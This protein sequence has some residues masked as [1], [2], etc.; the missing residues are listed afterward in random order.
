M[1]SNRISASTKFQNLFFRLRDW[2]LTHSNRC[3][4]F[5]LKSIEFES[6]P[7]VGMLIINSVIWVEIGNINSFWIECDTYQLSWIKPLKYFLKSNILFTYLNNNEA[8]EMNIIWIC[9]L[10]YTYS[11]QMKSW[12]ISIHKPVIDWLNS[13]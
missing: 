2:C 8:I 11:I 1:Y 3:L 4:L 9:N 6:K 13:R 7:S 12:N 10:H 5:T